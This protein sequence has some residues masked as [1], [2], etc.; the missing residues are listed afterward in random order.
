MIHARLI[1]DAPDEPYVCFFESGRFTTPILILP[2]EQ[3]KEI[4]ANIDKELKDVKRLQ[5]A[6]IKARIGGGR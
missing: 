3:V 5:N 1:F 6:R 4:A 2:V